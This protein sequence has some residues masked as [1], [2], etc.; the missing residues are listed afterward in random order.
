M[1]D[2]DFSSEYFVEAGV[3]YGGYFT[4]ASTSAPREDYIVAT[5]TP[6]SSGS[7]QVVMTDSTT[8]LSAGST[9]TYMAYLKTINGTY[10]P[11]PAKNPSTTNAVQFKIATKPDNVVY[12][13]GYEP[14]AGEEVNLLASDI[15]KFIHVMDRTNFWFTDNE[16]SG[17]D[18]SIV[19][20]GA[21]IRA[22]TFGNDN[23]FY[24]K[25]NDFGNYKKFT[26]T[27]ENVTAG[28]PIYA[29]NLIFLKTSINNMLGVL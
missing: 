15:C 18:E 6:S 2:Y 25:L 7:S 27:F 1:G 16:T 19:V 24:E 26:R 28:S 11:I 13:S 20:T 12:T 10:M 5:A 3:L 17:I 8:S 4:V 22:S 29:A 9:A 23:G 21:L 14:T